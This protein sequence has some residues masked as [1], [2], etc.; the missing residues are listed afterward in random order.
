MPRRPAWNGLTLVEVLVVVLIVSVLAALAL[1]SYHRYLQRGHRADAVRGLLQ[2]SGCQ[3]RI[4]AGT[5]YFDTGRCTAGLDT[6]RYR[7]RIEPPD[8][9]DTLTYTAIA[10]PVVAQA[11]DVCGELRLDQAGT[12]GIAGAP[13][14]LA[15]CW[16]GR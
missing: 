15:D 9:N 4:R 10:T 7:F 12:R 8:R 13:G 16:G 1:P 5:G 2:I 14:R 6:A 3:E 11:H